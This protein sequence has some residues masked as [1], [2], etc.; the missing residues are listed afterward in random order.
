MLKQIYT[1]AT[2]HPTQDSFCHP[3][4][5]MCGLIPLLCVKIIN[6]ADGTGLFK[7]NNLV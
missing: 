6:L 5:V 7:I 1:H 3:I 2:G 4:T